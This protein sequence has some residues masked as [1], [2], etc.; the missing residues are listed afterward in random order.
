[1]TIF[2]LFWCTVNFRK[3]EFVVAERRKKL[4]SKKNVDPDIVEAPWRSSMEEMLKFQKMI[5]L[6]FYKFHE[7]QKNHARKNLIFLFH[8]PFIYVD[9]KLSRFCVKFVEFLPIQFTLCVLRLFFFCSFRWNFQIKFFFFFS[10]RI[11]WNT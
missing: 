6:R 10:R 8:Y 11:P 5:E 1:M 3:L 4:R 9:R 7:I 2:L